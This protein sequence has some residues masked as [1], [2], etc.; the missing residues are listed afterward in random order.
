MTG[1][2]EYIQE[3][4]KT[5]KVRLFSCSMHRWLEPSN[6][7]LLCRDEMSFSAHLTQTVAFTFQAKLYEWYLQQ[8]AAEYDLW[9]EGTFS[10]LPVKNWLG[11]N[12]FGWW[13]CFVLADCTT[14]FAGSA[15][16]SP[17]CSRPLPECH[18]KRDFIWIYQNVPF[19]VSTEWAIKFVNVLW[20][21]NS[22]CDFSL[23]G[24]NSR[25]FCLQKD[26]FTHFLFRLF[27]ESSSPEIL[28]YLMFLW[29]YSG[30]RLRYSS[31]SSGSL[32]RVFVLCMYC[33]GCFVP[34]IVT[35]EFYRN[36]S[37]D[38]Q[39]WSFFLQ[40][41]R[42]VGQ[43]HVWTNVKLPVVDKHWKRN[44]QISMLPLNACLFL[45]FAHFLWIF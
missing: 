15:W 28:F 1:Y 20:K 26:L 3:V 45:R 7:H 4:V 39:F 32:Q 21:A 14:K 12:L 37:P 25:K 34:S 29:F 16:Q 35:L 17:R 41:I 9:P 10:L 22:R 24:I 5:K 23:T 38:R 13:G 42:S 11:Y 44:N 31:T 8:C 43:W 40:Y 2:S 30:I 19:L 33:I 18:C 6:F 36:L 27:K